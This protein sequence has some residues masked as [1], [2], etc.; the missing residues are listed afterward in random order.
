MGEPWRRYQ[1]GVASSAAPGAL[2]YAQDAS[3]AGEWATDRAKDQPSRTSRSGEVLTGDHAQSHK[4]NLGSF[5]PVEDFQPHDQ[6][7]SWAQYQESSH[8][9]DLP[10][11]PNE[12]SALALPSRSAS[13]EFYSPKEAAISGLPT[14]PQSLPP[15]PEASHQT[16]GYAGYDEP[17]VPTEAASFPPGF[18]PG[19]ENGKFVSRYGED[20]DPQHTRDMRLS[21]QSQQ[22][23]DEHAGAFQ[24]NYYRPYPGS[25]RPDAGGSSYIDESGHYLD[26]SGQR[27]HYST[28]HRQPSLPPYSPTKLSSG[29]LSQ[30]SHWPHGSNGEPLQRPHLPHH[31]S[32]PSYH[33]HL[34]NHGQLAGSFLPFLPPGGYSETPRST[35][36]VPGEARHNLHLSHLPPAPSWLVHPAQSRNGEADTHGAQLSPSAP[37]Q[38]NS[39]AHTI[40]GITP[41]MLTPESN[42]S[43]FPDVAPVQHYSAPQTYFDFSQQV[44]T[45]QGSHPAP[46][47][48]NQQSSLDIYDSPAVTIASLPSP[49]LFTHQLSSDYQGKG[50]PYSTT[51]GGVPEGYDYFQLNGIVNAGGYHPHYRGNTQQGPLV[52]SGTPTSPSFSGSA[53]HSFSY[54]S[55]AP[56]TSAGAARAVIDASGNAKSKGKR[57]NRKQDGICEVCLKTFTSI[58]LRGQDGDFNVSYKLSYICAA[59]AAANPKLQLSRRPAETVE[60]S[61]SSAEDSALA[62][63]TALTPIKTPSVATSGKG[64]DK[65]SK[66]R[67]RTSDLSSPAVC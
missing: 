61:A 42:K 12:T 9:A 47:S 41:D 60:V 10:S 36:S 38:M 7:T 17:F 64:K 26:S 66:K 63:V 4:Q 59:C 15:I 44:G 18:P 52:V 11:L 50:P 51:P 45:Q 23:K 31:S 48:H 19:I 27:P 30:P 6:H 62:P 55:S 16:T 5:P 29:G 24:P 28:Q 20:A 37:M 67:T 57:E 13:A 14:L 65:G 21:W 49:A 32:Y 34:P 43:Y 8:H 1:D 22:N 25:D 53:Q 3:S 56:S 58:Y 54:R 40:G 39:V 46:I 35:S 2:N 33:A